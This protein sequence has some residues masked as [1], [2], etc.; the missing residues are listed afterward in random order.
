VCNPLN[1][2]GLTTGLIDVA[3]LSR[4]LPQAFFGGAAATPWQG[5]LKK[6]ATL[7]RKDVVE[8]VQK[9]TIEGKLRIH[10]Q[11]PKVVAQRDDFFNMLNKN[12]G[13]GM[14]VAGTLTETVPDDLSPS[15]V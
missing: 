1:A 2:L 12:P 9:Q 5:L 4:L 13:F 14:F 7:R 8:R 15:P 3:Y 10:S 11:D 6:Y